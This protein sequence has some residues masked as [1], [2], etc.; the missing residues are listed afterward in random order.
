ML[1]KRVATVLGLAALA[2]KDTVETRMAEL[3]TLPMVLIITVVV[4]PEH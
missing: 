3:E 4:E 2:F 1:A